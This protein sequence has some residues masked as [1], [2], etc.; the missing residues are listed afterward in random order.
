MIKMNRKVLKMIAN[1]RYGKKPEG[2]HDYEDIPEEELD[3]N[4]WWYLHGQLQS[5]VGFDK[6][7][8]INCMSGGFAKETIHFEEIRGNQVVSVF[9]ERPWFNMHFEGEVDVE[10]E[11]I[12]KPCKGFFWIAGEKQV[13]W[14]GRKYD[15]WNQRGLVCYADDEWACN[16]AKKKMIEKPLVF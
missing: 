3:H 7:V 13:E 12:D 8:V 2:T 6:A 4:S 14:K 9:D 15:Y 10:I 11:G 1:W 16:D 5:D